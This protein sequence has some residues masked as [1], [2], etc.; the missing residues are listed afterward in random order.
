MA[1]AVDRI[2]GYTGL[3]YYVT[4]WRS[5]SVIG[6]S[7]LQCR[8]KGYTFSCRLETPLAYA[9]GFDVAHFPMGYLEVG[10]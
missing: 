3:F 8:P 2:I 4:M 10:G 6:L 5:F 1:T 7:S 9:Y